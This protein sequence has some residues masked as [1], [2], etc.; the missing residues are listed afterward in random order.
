MVVK[1]ST[2]LPSF[3]TELASLTFQFPLRRFACVSSGSVGVGVGVDPSS[4]PHEMITNE[5]N[6]AK[7]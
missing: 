7:R 5:N 1:T 4:S 2:I 6:I 3:V